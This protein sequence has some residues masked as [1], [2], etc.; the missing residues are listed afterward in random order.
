MTTLVIVESHAKV[1]KIAA[2]PRTRFKV[3]ASVGHVRDLP[4]KEMGIIKRQLTW[5][6]WRK[7]SW[8][9]VNSCTNYSETQYYDSFSDLPRPRTLPNI[10][11]IG[12]WLSSLAS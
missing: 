6:V 1:K 5:S 4:Q 3:V 10:S 2:L 11:A 8:S 7:L 9:S 12:L